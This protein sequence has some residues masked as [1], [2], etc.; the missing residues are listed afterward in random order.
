MESFTFA[1]GL[2]SEILSAWTPRVILTI[3][4]KTFEKLKRILLGR[5]EARVARR[6]ALPTGWGNSK[7]EA[8]RIFVSG[9]EEAVTLVRLPH[10]A[11][12]RLMGK[13]ECWK[14]VR[15]FLDCVYAPT[16]NATCAT[17]PSQCV[18]MRGPDLCSRWVKDIPSPEAYAAFR[19]LVDISWW[20]P[21]L[22]LNHQQNRSRL[23]ACRLYDC[24]DR[25]PCSFTLN[26]KWPL[27]YFRL[28]GVRRDRDR[29]EREFESFNVNN[30][31]EW[32]VRLRNEADVWRLVEWVD[33]LD[34]N[35]RLV[36]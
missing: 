12:I 23:K 13:E 27:F 9:D 20:T 2:W 10:L 29:W 5:S 17:G 22:A 25:Q 30:K 34:C 4:C 6:M 1:E 35:R 24:S 15:E 7:M 16:R 14:A 26:K 33:A 18:G 21:H 28:P 19:L 8:M 32:T 11:R 31:R 3:A 36:R